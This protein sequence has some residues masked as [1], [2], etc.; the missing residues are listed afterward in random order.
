M[1][2]DQRGSYVF[3]LARLLSMFVVNIDILVYYLF[4]RHQ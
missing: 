1:L 4:S 3:S 2:T